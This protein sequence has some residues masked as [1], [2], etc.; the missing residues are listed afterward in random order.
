[1]VAPEPWG[2]DTGIYGVFAM[3]AGWPQFG[4]WIEPHP[5]PGLVLPWGLARE[6]VWGSGL[7]LGR[8]ASETSLVASLLCNPRQFSSPSSCVTLHK[9]G[10][11]MALLNG[12]R[13]ILSN[14]LAVDCK[15]TTRT[16]ACPE[17]PHL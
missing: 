10:M 15:M 3:S 4:S 12:L 14:I 9:M 6:V 2:G 17:Q 16:P 8:W 13:V 7:V 11:Y 5:L 1:M